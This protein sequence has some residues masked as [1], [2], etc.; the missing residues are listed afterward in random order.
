MSAL[1]PALSNLMVHLVILKLQSCELPPHELKL[2]QKRLN[3]VRRLVNHAPGSGSL[4]IP[5]TR[6]NARLESVG[7]PKPLGSFSRTIV[8][9]L[10]VPM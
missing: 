1:H 2:S 8:H 3:D 6:V 9:S 10:F 4:P 5:R 7:L